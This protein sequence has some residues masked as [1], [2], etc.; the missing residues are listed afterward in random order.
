MSKTLEAREANA[1]LVKMIDRYISDRVALGE[2]TP[3]TAEVTQNRLYL[4]AVA[5]RGVPPWE[6]TKAQVKEWMASM[7]SI[8][9]STKAM[10]YSSVNSLYE[11]AIAEGIVSHNPCIGVKRPKTPRGE[12]RSLSATEIVR[13]AEH[14]QDKS[15]RRGM[16]MFSLMYGEGLRCGEVAR[17]QL[18]DIDHHEGVIHVRGKG[19]KGERSRS[20]ALSPGTVEA[21]RRYLLHTKIEGGPLFR[22][23]SDRSQG[24]TP[25]SVSEVMSK[26]MSAAGIKHGRYDGVSAHALRHTAAEELAAATDDIRVVQQ[27]LGHENLATTNLY[28][29]SEVKGQAAAQAARFAPKIAPPEPKSEIPEFF[30]EPRHRNYADGEELIG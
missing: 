29:R 22:N 6:I 4:F 26:Y 20:V 28:L 15:P 12:N 24:T 5:M 3:K 18:H 30:R 23:Q 11:W 17:V 25:R 2:Y 21:L 1:P 16:L 7:G 13:L 19:Y 27:F 10:R 14:I 8:R 9:N